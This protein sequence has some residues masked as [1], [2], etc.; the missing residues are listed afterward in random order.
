VIQHL[1][2]AAVV[3][4]SLEDFADMDNTPHYDDARRNLV[5][6]V[7]RD[8]GTMLDVGCGGG[9][10]GRSVHEVRPDITIFGVEPD[11]IGARHAAAAPYAQVAEGFFPEAADQLHVE[12]F[13]VIFFNDVL[14]HMAEP[15]SAVIAAK[16]HLAPGGMVV[17][18]IPNVRHM[19]VW[20]PLI[21]RGRWQYEDYGILDR[22]HL[23]FF[24]E[25]S[26]RQLFEDNGWAVVS[27][28][29]VNRTRQ[30]MRPGED[31]WKS[32]ALSRLTR[33]RSDPFLWT[34]YVLQ[35]VPF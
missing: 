4:P 28:E 3:A 33:G 27:S 15:G 22:T 14:E 35:A 23:R 19:S 32:V 17:A 16:E 29:G 31:G 8:A 9:G 18:C 5:R 25:S 34:Q 1:Y 6:F 20:W 24:T 30:P 26:M 21:R 2:A 10:F 13:D 12:R 7:P 11:P